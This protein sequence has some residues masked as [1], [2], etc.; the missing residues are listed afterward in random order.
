MTELKRKTE[1]RRFRLK[2]IEDESGV[3]G[4]GYVSEGIKFSNGNCVITWLT[5]TSSMGIYHSTVE[6]LHIHGHSGRTIIE[7]IDNENATGSG[8]VLDN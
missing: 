6:L 5:D 8:T 3:S 1:M 7:W 2:R 4:T